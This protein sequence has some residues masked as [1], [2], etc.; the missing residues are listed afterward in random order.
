MSGT[1]LKVSSFSIA[2]AM[3]PVLSLELVPSRPLE[4]SSGTAFEADLDSGSCGLNAELGERVDVRP[5]GEAEASCGGSDGSGKEDGM[6]IGR[7][8]GDEGLELSCGA[9]VGAF[10]GSVAEAGE[11]AVVRS[12]KSS[13]CRSDLGPSDVAE[14]MTGYFL[15]MS[16]FSIAVA[17]IPVLY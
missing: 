7:D 6:R 3:I 4:C 5:G 1:S 15:K 14:K 11:S 16:S 13:S 8:S 2:V 12:F 9:G 10:L 17:M